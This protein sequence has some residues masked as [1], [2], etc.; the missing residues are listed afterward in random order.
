MSLPVGGPSPINN[1]NFKVPVKTSVSDNTNIKVPTTPEDV[2]KQ[3]ESNGGINSS[4]KIATREA[5]SNI[6]KELKFVVPQEALA[7]IDSVK[8]DRGLQPQI[9]DRTN[10]KISSDNY[11]K[12]DKPMTF[13]SSKSDDKYFLEKATSITIG[14]GVEITQ[15]PTRVKMKH[16]ET[17]KT[18]EAMSVKLSTGEEFFVPVGQKFS[19]DIKQM[20]GGTTLNIGEKGDVDE[21]RARFSCAFSSRNVIV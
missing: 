13:N 15:E 6:N 16:P 12:S 7:K 18:I 11:I 14:D 9:P 8:N 3:P 4:V 1:F 5:L 17:G 21:I 10:V 2:A 20:I 19:I